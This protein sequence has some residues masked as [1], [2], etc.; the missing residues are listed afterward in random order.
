MANEIAVSDAEIDQLTTEACDAVAGIVQ[1]T[2][3]QT[4]GDIA[5]LHFHHGSD[6]WTSMRCIVVDYLALEE[7]HL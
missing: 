3:G 2:I 5:G 4:A 6:A 7:A 1:K